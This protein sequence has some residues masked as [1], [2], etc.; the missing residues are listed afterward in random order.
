MITKDH[1][2]KEGGLFNHLTVTCAII[3]SS[4]IIAYQKYCYQYLNHKMQFRI[5]LTANKLISKL[6]VSQPPINL[7]QMC[8]L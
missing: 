7:L 4:P 1:N 2:I 3:S 6:Y 5:N 8:T